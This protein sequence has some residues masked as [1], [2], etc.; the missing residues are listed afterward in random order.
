MVAAV[1]CDN[2]ASNLVRL[3][4]TGLTHGVDDLNRIEPGSARRFNYDDFASLDDRRSADMRRRNADGL[5]TR[6]EAS[7]R[8]PDTAA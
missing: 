5:A 7:T 4:D 1:A 6:R 8:R 3:R 2:T